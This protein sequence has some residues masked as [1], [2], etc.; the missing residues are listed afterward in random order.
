MLVGSLLIGVALTFDKSHAGAIRSLSRQLPLTWLINEAKSDVVVTTWFVSVCV[1]AGV[2]FLH[3]VCCLLT[4]LF[5]L[6]QNTVSA[7]QWLFYT[8]IAQRTTQGLRG[9]RVQEH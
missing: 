5:R 9:H 2:F 7:K 4:R 6:I 3:L 1:I 8:I